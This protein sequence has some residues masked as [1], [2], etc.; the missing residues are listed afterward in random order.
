MYKLYVSLG[1]KIE[2]KQMNR[3]QSKYVVEGGPTVHQFHA[4][5]Q[6]EWHMIILLG[7]LKVT[8]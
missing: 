4:Y 2:A 6:D 3:K 1:F 5:S 7:V 8:Q